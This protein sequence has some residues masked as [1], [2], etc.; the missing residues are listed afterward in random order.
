MI[1]EIALEVVRLAG[2][3]LAS[4]PMSGAGSVAHRALDTIVTGGYGD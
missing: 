4:D 1:P 2:H 3:Y